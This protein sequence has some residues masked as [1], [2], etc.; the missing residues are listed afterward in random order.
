MGYAGTFLQTQ[1]QEKDS[2]RCGDVSEVFCCLEKGIF[3]LFC[4][5]V[6]SWSSIFVSGDVEASYLAPVSGATTGTGFFLF[7]AFSLGLH[8]PNSLSF[9]LKIL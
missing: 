6:S 5:G 4:S 9:S 2:L 8:I 1:Y 7:N 3:L